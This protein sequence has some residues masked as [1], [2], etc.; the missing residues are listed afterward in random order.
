LS[1]TAQV[2][3]RSSFHVAPSEDVGD[4]SLPRVTIT[5]AIAGSLPVTGP[6]ANDVDLFAI[7]LQA[8]EKLILDIDYAFRP[9]SQMNAQLFLMDESGKVLVEADDAPTSMGGT[10]S[11]SPRDPYLEFT[12]DGSGGTYYVAVSTWNNDPLGPSGKFNDFGFMP[13][14]YVLNVSI[15]NPTPDLGAF[16]VTPD[17]LLANDFDADGESLVITNV[18]NGIN[19]KVELINTGDIL[20][21]PGADSPG[22]FEYTVRDGN[23]GESTATVTVNGNRIVGTASDD[24]LAGTPEPD[25]FVGGDGSDTFNFS[26]G[27]GNDTIADFARGIDALAITDSMLVHD[28]QTLGNDTLVNFDTGDSVLLVGV[29]G[30]TDVNDLFV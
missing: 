14:E 4:D 5:G 13:G 26:T 23:G 20:F 11:L 18:G 15:D 10:G 3:E 24:V 7:T 19:G 28:F 9:E 22:S 2:I 29:S 6:N 16:V 27:T 17:K 25:L 12:D 1:A 8:G 21:K 30:V